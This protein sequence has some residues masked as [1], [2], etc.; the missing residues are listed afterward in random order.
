MP[1]KRKHE[2][3]IGQHFTWKLFRRSGVYQADGRSNPVS[4]GRH[5]L[6]TTDR[7]EAM[8][9]LKKLDLFV[10][11]DKGLADRSVLDPD[12][13][14]MLPIKQGVELYMEHAKRPAVARGTTKGTQT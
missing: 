8:E 13:P 3:M 2:Q 10:A 9:N 1:K 4:G 12:G 14:A 7:L 5:S 11:V 6:G